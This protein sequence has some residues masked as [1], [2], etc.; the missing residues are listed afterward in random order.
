VSVRQHVHNDNDENSAGCQR[1]RSD[2]LHYLMRLNR[3]ERLLHRLRHLYVVA[4]LP[5]QSQAAG[6]EY[7]KWQRDEKDP[8]SPHPRRVPRNDAVSGVRRFVLQRLRRTNDQ[9]GHKQNRR[10]H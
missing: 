9:R 4:Q 6:H 5:Q 3:C 10:E 7:D 2:E 8:Q 1:R